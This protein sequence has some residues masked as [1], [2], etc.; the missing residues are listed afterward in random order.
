MLGKIFTP[1][2]IIKK[3]DDV[4]LSAVMDDEEYLTRKI[5]ALLLW[6][7]CR[8]FELGRYNHIPMA[9]FVYG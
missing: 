1:D 6:V 3:I 5:Y 2:D 8:R 7:N 4:D 9:G